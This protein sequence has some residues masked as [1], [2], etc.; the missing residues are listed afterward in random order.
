MPISLGPQWNLRNARYCI[1]EGNTVV[2]NTEGSW[3]PIEQENA[4]ELT[5]SFRRDGICA[6][7]S[8]RNL[9]PSDDCSHYLADAALELDVVGDR[10][11][12]CDFAGQVWVDAAAD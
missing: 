11:A 9:S 2:F 8:L 10:A 7:D 5:E 4:E 3:N 12:Y 1:T 6:G